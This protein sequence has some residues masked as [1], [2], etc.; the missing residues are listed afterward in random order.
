MPKRK[1][2]PKITPVNVSV[3]NSTTVE[4]DG[5]ARSINNLGETLG[6]GL[7]QLGEN[8]SLAFADSQAELA[9]KIES[10]IRETSTNVTDRLDKQQ[11][12]IVEQQDLFNA[13]NDKQNSK[14]NKL[15]ALHQREQERLSRKDVA[16]EEA[17]M[18]EKQGPF[19]EMSL[20]LHEIRDI[21]KA[22]GLGKPKEEEG[23]SFLGGL[24]KSLLGKG[25]GLLRQGASM[26][27]RAAMGALATPV[28]LAAGGAAVLGGG[29]MYLMNKEVEKARAEGG[30][31]AAEAKGAE[32]TQMIL[33]AGNPDMA[34]AEAIQN[35]GE[36]K[37]P[38]PKPPAPP[39][40]PPATPAMAAPSAKGVPSR[41]P[42]AL[43]AAVTGVSPTNQTAAT[44]ARTGV[45]LTSEGRSAAPPLAGNEKPGTVKAGSPAGKDGE[46]IKRVV[47]AGPGFNVVETESGK[48]EKRTGPRNWRNNNPG[49]INYSSFSQKQGALG[50]DPRFAIFPSYSEGREAK[51]A[52]LFDS[53]SYANLKVS[54]AI[55]RYAPPSENN[56][57]NYVQTI[58]D[59]IGGTDVPL[60]DLNSQQREAMLNAMERME[61]FKEGKTEVLKQ[62]TASATPAATPATEPAGKSSLEAAP[63]TP[64]T[65]GS[66]APVTSGSGAPVTTEA[67]RSEGGSNLT[68]TPPPQES[69]FGKLSKALG[70]G[71]AVSAADPSAP[72]P[73]GEAGGPTPKLEEN[74]KLKDASVNL[75]GL[76]PNMKDR[77][78]RMAAEFQEKTGKKLQINSGFRDPKEQAELYAKYGSPR[79]APPG[80]SRHESGIA[81]DMNSGDAA[82]AISLGLFD[83]YGFTRP[84]PGETWHIEPVETAKRGAMPDNPYSPGQAIAV[85]GK[86]GKPIIPASGEAP[87]IKEPPKP[88]TSESAPSA[89]ATTLADASAPRGEASGST[90]AAEPTAKPVAVGDQLASAESVNTSSGLQPVA[91][92][93]AAQNIGGSAGTNIAA[94]SEKASAPAAQAPVVIN[95]NSTNNTMAGGGGGSGGIPSPYGNRGS[96]STSTTFIAAA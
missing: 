96:L 14:F 10:V 95:N 17:R 80:K 47:E 79:A 18:E 22:G 50:A 20:V 30:D 51:R 24:G 92:G 73:A 5:V 46:K 85:A 2:L 45:A 69:L 6:D 34:F 16:D 32:H 70:F 37:A 13:H 65:S 88:A 23:G 84:V 1:S 75:S 43:P 72:A 39:S 76:D 66:G 90:A 36:N 21:L 40:P 4:L 55:A 74:V 48:V 86:G 28:G 7:N 33:G 44:A 38:P 56:T 87:A 15:L 93:A 25:G 26:A 62:A 19:T 29:A 58:L 11:A 78:A 12:T 42:S 89:A 83:K 3:T 8:I 91:G 63:S 49:N 61:G 31:A 27:G 54:D 81:F 41:T 52:L 67:P 64:V 35:A 68:S 9:S 94:L 60:K 82:T 59:A 77:M 57:S 53:P 71:P